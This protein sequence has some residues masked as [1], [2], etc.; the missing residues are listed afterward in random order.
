MG[1][2]LQGAGDKLEIRKEE[3][4]PDNSI[5]NIPLPVW[6]KIAQAIRELPVVKRLGLELESQV[7]ISGLFRG[8]CTRELNFADIAVALP[9]LQPFLEV[10]CAPCKGT[11]KLNGK[12]CEI[13]GGDGIVMRV[14]RR[15]PRESG[16]L[17][18]TSPQGCRREEG[19]ELMAAVQELE[20]IQTNHLYVQPELGAWLNVDTPSPLAKFVLHLKRELPE[21]R[22]KE[23]QLRISENE[24]MMRLWIQFISSIRDDPKVGLG[25]IRDGLGKDV[26][27]LKKQVRAIKRKLGL[28]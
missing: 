7:E 9:F 3:P 28:K 10:S 27:E 2:R 11:G 22:E 4:W 20:I 23:R 19:E 24:R 1:D 21:Q 16:K 18:V 17:D 15:A 8:V 13:C 5:F 12:K 26:V 6:A 14:P 25:A